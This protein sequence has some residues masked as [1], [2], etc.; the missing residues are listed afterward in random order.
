MSRDVLV[1]VAYS[2]RAKKWD[3]SKK[4]EG[5]GWGR[6]KKETSAHKFLAFE[7]HPLGPLAFPVEFIYWLTTLSTN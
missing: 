5:A 1:Q 7:D 6:G 3:E 2:G 4:L